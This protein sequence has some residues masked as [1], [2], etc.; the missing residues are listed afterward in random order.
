M[1]PHIFSFPPPIPEAL[2]VLLLAVGIDLI[3]GEPPARVHPVVLMGRMIGGLRRRAGP[4]RWWLVTRSLTL[5][6]FV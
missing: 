1:I 2:A 4:T 6:T 3:L 5:V